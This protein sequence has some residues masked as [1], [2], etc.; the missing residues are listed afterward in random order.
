MKKIILIS[1][2]VILL[3]GIG[4]YAGCYFSYNNKEITLRTQ[5]EAQRGRVEGCLLR[6][7]CVR[8]PLS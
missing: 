7:R 1:L 5:A 6:L 2:A 4:V 8:L 3:I